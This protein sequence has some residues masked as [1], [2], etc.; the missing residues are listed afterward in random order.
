MKRIVSILL[1]MAIIISGSI[2]AARAYDLDTIEGSDYMD[3]DY[4]DDDGT[5]YLLDPA[6]NQYLK[7]NNVEAEI[8]RLST[9]NERDYTFERLF[10]ERRAEQKEQADRL[11]DESLKNKRAS[12][13]PV[14]G[15][16]GYGTFY[17][18]A[19]QHNFT[20]GTTL[21]YDIIC[22]TKPGGDVN[23]YLYLTG[24]NRAAK[25][26]E[27]FVSYYS[28]NNLCFK[29]YDWARPK[30]SRWQTNLSYAQLS[31]YLTTKT[32]NGVS[33]QIITVQN[34]TIQVSPTRWKNI[35][36]LTNYSTN[37]FD[38]IY[39]Y[40]Y[41]AT[42]SEQKHPHLGSWAAAVETFQD[43]YYQDLNVMGFNLVYVK[44]RN[45]DYTSST[46]ENWQLLT[47]SVS[48]RRNDNK[49]LTLVFISPNHTFGVK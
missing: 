43:Y 21:S 47:S 19:F 20:S 13:P 33:R 26:V 28:Q 6:T 31:N 32:I 40:E 39:S 45:T 46:W 16:C 17:K 27:A 49:G 3:V 4:I 41:T 38:Q 29:I 44:G 36:W 35:V 12:G 1:V 15:D 30:S 48:T 14:P 18:S 9:M 8:A 34:T 42:L 7:V 5:K 11:M 37:S 2:P 10:E 23:T 24:M 25:S 22:P